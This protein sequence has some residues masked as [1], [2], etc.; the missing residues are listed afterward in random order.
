[1]ITQKNETKDG[2]QIVHF[3]L[4]D[5]LWAD[6]IFVVGT[7]NQQEKYRCAMQQNRDG[8]WTLDLKVPTDQD[9]NFRYLVDDHWM[10]DRIMQLN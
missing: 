9:V 6:R 7:I 8:S 5:S 1:M 4:P 2:H 3:E 10:M